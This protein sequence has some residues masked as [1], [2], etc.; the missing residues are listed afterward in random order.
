MATYIQSA[1]PVKYS[2]AA[3]LCHKGGDT[4]S[5]HYTARIYNPEDKLWYNYD[6][7]RVTQLKKVDFEVGETEFEKKSQVGSK[8]IQKTLEEDCFIPENSKSSKMKSPK[9]GLKEK[10][11]NFSSTNAY[12]LVYRPISEKPATPTIV[13]SYLKDII[14][15]EN[16]E[17]KNKLKI[18]Q[19]ELILF[20][21]RRKS[22]ENIYEL[23]SKMWKEI[24]SSWEAGEAT[25]NYIPTNCL[26]RLIEKDFSNVYNEKNDGVIIIENNII[27][28]DEL[29][30]IHGKLDPEKLGAS[31]R[32]SPVLHFLIL[33]SCG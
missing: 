30:C 21:F 13:P 14:S 10:I 33:G 3:V 9:H 32:L 16:A 18:L 19:D 8:S 31:K 20:K 24:F 23:K 22:V 28:C 12:V 2:L 26:E 15:R 29:S 1:K 17:Y 4:N 5:G 27:N 25:S 7:E 6:D 11:T